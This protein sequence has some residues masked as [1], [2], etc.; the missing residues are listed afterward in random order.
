MLTDPISVLFLQTRRGAER[1]EILT[2]MEKKGCWVD[3]AMDIE[4]V[5]AYLDQHDYD[6]FLMD[7]SDISIGECLPLIQKIKP[8]NV[9]IIIISDRINDKWHQNAPNLGVSGI[10]SEP[11]NP[12]ILEGVIDNCTKSRNHSFSAGG[13]NR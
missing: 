5:Y 7:I 1:P 13:G 4:E 12:V 9:A 6:I 3:K 8:L 11:I 2:P 10:F